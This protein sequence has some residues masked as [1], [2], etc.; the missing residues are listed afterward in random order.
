MAGCE[1]PDT[2]PISRK[3]DSRKWNVPRRFLPD[4][5]IAAVL[6]TL[7]S[8]PEGYREKR[9]YNILGFIDIHGDKDWPYR[10]PWYEL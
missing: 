1:F 6:R 10:H 9:L 5:R 7:V 8:V 4:D 2:K 3:H